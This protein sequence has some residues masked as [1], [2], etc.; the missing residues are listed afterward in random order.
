MAM[1]GHVILSHGSDSGPDA[2]KVSA[3][4][5]VAEALGWSTFRPDYR[6]EDKLGY[7]GCVQPRV[8]RLVA[9]MRGQPRPLVLAGSSMGAFVAGMASLQA[10]CDGLF[11]MALPIDIPGCPRFAAADGVRGMLVHGYR[12]ELCPIDA[13]TAFARA[14]GMPALLVDDGH[15]LGDHLETLERQFALFLRGYPD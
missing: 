2:T 14:R 4:A 15:R 1:P 11:L 9:A 5:R 8:A 13:A 10:A 3:L 6:A 12:D 7:A